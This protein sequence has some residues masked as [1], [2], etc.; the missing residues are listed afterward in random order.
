MAMP[1]LTSEE[2]DIVTQYLQAGI[3]RDYDNKKSIKMSLE[4]VVE[5]INAMNLNPSQHTQ[6]IL[7][8]IVKD[9]K[10]TK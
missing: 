4:Q 7:D 5:K 9:I 3:R 1:H 8:S 2:K 10:E 6:Q